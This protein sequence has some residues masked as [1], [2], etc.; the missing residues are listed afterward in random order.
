MRYVDD[1]MLRQCPSAGSRSS[2]EGLFTGTPVRRSGLIGPLLPAI[3][4][5][6]PHLPISPSTAS[7]SRSACPVK[8][9][10]VCG[11]R[12]RAVEAV[13][14]LV[15]QAGMIEVR[16]LADGEVEVGAHPHAGQALDSVGWP[17][18]DEAPPVG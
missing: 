11:Q 16:V 12:S 5:E 8:G 9:T 4:P 13:H 2:H 3:Q 6:G 7:Q 10:N 18:A 14:D 1:G 15:G 17:F